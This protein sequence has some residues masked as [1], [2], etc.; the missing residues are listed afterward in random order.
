MFLQ[1]FSPLSFRPSLGQC[2]LSAVGA[3][4][5]AGPASNLPKT[6][7]QIMPG[8]LCH[9]SEPPLNIKSGPTWWSRHPPLTL[10]LRARAAWPPC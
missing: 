7:Y 8:A 1:G 4:L 5:P 2:C 10:P 3:G 6:L 9:D